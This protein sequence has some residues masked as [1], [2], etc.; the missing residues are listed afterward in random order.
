MFR[1]FETAS[2]DR[3]NRLRQPENF[4]AEIGRR[5]AREKTVD[6]VWLLLGFRLWGKRRRRFVIPVAD[7][8]CR[9]SI[10][11]RKI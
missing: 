1:H 11:F 5:I 2:R 6:K 8:A 10:L 4:N 7:G 9:W 3:R